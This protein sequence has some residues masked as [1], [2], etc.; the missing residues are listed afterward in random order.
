MNKKFNLD[1][2]LID[3]AANI[4]DIS[5]ELPKNFAG[6]HLAGQLVRSGTSPALNYGEAQ[7]AESRNDFI[8]KMKISA[9][10]LR[11]SYNCLRI[12]RK[13][14]WVAEKEIARILDENNQLISIFVK[15]IETAKRN[16]E[17]EGNKNFKQ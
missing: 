11:E 1:E 4:I 9:K 10:E 14:N 13:K 17:K 12:I 3:F 6:S 2:R 7:S 16:N 5:E 15:S 8:H